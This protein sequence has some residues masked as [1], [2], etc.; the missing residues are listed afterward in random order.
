MGRRVEPCSDATTSCRLAR[1]P[2][3]PPLMLRPAVIKAKHW[4]IVRARFGLMQIFPRPH[5]KTSP[6]CCIDRSRARWQASSQQKHPLHRF[7]THIYTRT[8]RRTRA[9]GRYT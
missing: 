5:K 2:T 3:F 8:P 4:H 6:I 1:G 9:Q 7:Y